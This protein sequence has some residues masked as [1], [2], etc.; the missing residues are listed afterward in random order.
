MDKQIYNLVLEQGVD[1]AHFLSEGDGAGMQVKSNLNMFDGL[2]CML[3]TEAEAETLRNS[4]SVKEIMIEFKPEPT[5]YP[6]QT[7]ESPARLVT[8]P[9]PST[10]NPGST[11]AGTHFFH[12]GEQGG[13]NATG[14]VGFFTLSGEDNDVPGETIV[15]RFAGQ[16]VD[17]VA[18]EAGTPSATYDGYE[19]HPDFQ[20]REPQTF[21]ITA[22]NSGSSSW[23]LTG[24]DRNGSFSSEPNRSLVIYGG[25]TIN[26]T[27]NA[28]AAHPIELVQ[29]ALSTQVAGVTNQGAFGGQ[30]MSWTPTVSNQAIE[31]T[32]RCTVHTSS[33][34]GS[35]SSNTAPSRFIKTD[36]SVYDPGA[37]D[38]INNQV[39]NNTEYFDDHAI[40][41][42]SVAG[43]SYC[44]W[45]KNSDLRV[46][47]TSDGISVAY[48][49]ALEFHKNKP[50]N[51][52]TGRRN[53]TIVTGAFGY[54]SF[55]YD[56]AVPI[57]SITKINAYDEEGNLIEINRPG[58]GWGTDF[59]PFTDNLLVPRIVQDPADNTNKW[60][61]T[62]PF[63]FRFTAFD[64]IMNSYNAE[65]GIYHFKSAGNYG[66]VSVKPSDPRWNT[67]IEN[68]AN[69]NFSVGVTSEQFS[70]LN[71]STGT[72]QTRFPLRIFDGGATN[73]ITVAAFQNSTIN[74][75]LDAYSTRGPVVDVSGTGA[76]TWSAYPGTT[77]SDGQWGYFS[78][79]SCS[80]PQAAGVATLIIE[81]FLTQRGLYPSIAQ[82]KEL[83]EKYSKPLDGESTID[84]S[85]VPAISDYSQP[86]LYFASDVY[87]LKN[88]KPVN[89]GMD[90]S[91]LHG[92]PSTRIFA[93]WGIYMGTG[94]YIADPR[95][96]NFGKRPISG[97]T[98]PRRKIRV[99]S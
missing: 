36:W 56:G 31:V 85:N 37:A 20:I 43:G 93:P 81:N 6:T 94:Q 47:Y 88:N 18:I 80:A 46:I 87:S 60:C 19:T 10:S 76:F 90:L 86:R 22:I 7:K 83:I 27:N 44:G 5:F 95:G 64:T 24:T 40:G 34:A 84:W 69:I 89:G 3:L 42:L 73:M 72:A 91:D 33:M 79:T 61:I 30:I 16:Y 52:E 49:A 39:T 26:I 13:T 71:P 67:N 51:P 12:S 29:G 68:T 45:A 99:G 54:P 55:A 57:D 66:T 74:P 35:L 4:S 63:N 28:S 14:P 97:Q 65:N 50:I 25:D 15:Q 70:T 8:G 23:L 17:I 92:T 82:L 2:L 1:E 96:P 38:P 98:Y 78:G 21:N 41:V 11:Y 77:Y 32:Y 53:A 9:N 75:L 62:Y 48:N 58:A 59:T